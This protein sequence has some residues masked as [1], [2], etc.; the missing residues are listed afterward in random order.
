M[1]SSLLEL[2]TLRPAIRKGRVAALAR[3]CDGF[4]L[5]DGS[6]RLRQRAG[7]RPLEHQARRDRPRR[8]YL[9]R[10]RRGRGPRQ[11]AQSARG[12]SHHARLRHPAF[13]EPS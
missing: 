5:G 12:K 4:L 10:L 7:V 11:A 1:A 13:R 8:E 2:P 3:A 6:R 9:R